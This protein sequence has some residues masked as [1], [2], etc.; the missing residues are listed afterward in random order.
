MVPL[1]MIAEGS[2]DVAQGVLDRLYQVHGHM[3]PKKPRLEITK[4]NQNVAVYLKA[5]NTIQLEE[6]A[7]LLCRSFGKDSLAALAFILG[8]EL[9]HAVQINNVLPKTSFISYD[10]SLKSSL[11]IE[12]NADVQGIFLSYL[13]GFKT[14]HLIPQI[15]D[16]MYTV[17]E[18]RSKNLRGYPT[19]QERKASYK[20]VIDQANQLIELF[21]LAN[22]MSVIQEYKAAIQ[23]LEYI[24][25]FYQGKEI[26]NNLGVNYTLMALNF[27]RLNGEAYVYPLELDW[28]IRIK[29]PKT[30]RGEEPVDT[31]ER[32]HQ[33]QLFRKAK[34]YFSQASQLDRDYTLAELNIF[35]VM[36]MMDEHANARQF[37]KNQ[38][39][40]Y[41][42]KTGKG[43]LF[44]KIKSANAI[45]NAKQNN[46]A[47]A[48]KI[49]MD[50]TQEK[51]EI[52]STQASQNIVVLSKN[53]PTLSGNTVFQ[54][55]GINLKAVHGSDLKLRNITTMD[56]IELDDKNWIEKKSLDGYTV[57]G[58]VADERQI[59][60]V[61][62]I[63]VQSRQKLS[64]S[65][66]SLVSL[67]NNQWIYR[68]NKDNIAYVINEQGEVD[69]I[70]RYVRFKENYE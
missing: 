27:T 50:L 23:C 24:S 25:R 55:A 18:L 21:H 16:K 9:I 63:T 4:G 41:S 67:G 32:M 10:K 19:E 52:I 17:Y 64:V 49:W 47:E 5:K 46:T 48:L 44:L 43:D 39:R 59:I 69:Y 38:L 7:Y 8:H 26:Y 31:F 62:K 61:Q 12:Q 22:E 6:Q 20:T 70:V 30:G 57:Y 35:C 34:D 68:C 51:N 15:I 3:N 45:L 42:S 40:S 33:M 29:K 36:I 28:S 54:C 13:A 66:T 58:F 53:K 37:Y 11:E 60:N 2:H 1:C 56:W 65:Q 14:I